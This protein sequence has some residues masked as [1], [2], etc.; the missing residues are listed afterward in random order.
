[1]VRSGKALLSALLALTIPA[2]AGAADAP[3]NDPGFERFGY[4]RAGAGGSADGGRQRCFQ[5]PGA[6]AKYRLGNECDIYGE[7]GVAGPVAGSADGP[8]FSVHARGSVQRVNTPEPVGYAVAEAWA[9]GSRVLPGLLDTAMVWAGQRFYRRED[10]PINDFFYWDATGTGGGVQDVAVGA[11]KLAY[12]FFRDIDAPESGS[13]LSGKGG[14]IVVGASLA[15]QGRPVIHR[16]DLRLYDVPVNPEGLLTIGGDIRTS[17]RHTGFMATVQHSQT[18]AL[19]GRNRLALQYGQGAAFALSRVSDLAAGPGRRTVRAVDDVT[20]QL[21]PDWSGMLAGVV[22]RR[23][24]PNADERQTWYSAGVRAIH[25]VTDHLAAAVEVG[26]DIVQPGH[27]PER[28]LTKITFAPLLTAGR[29]LSDR[30]QVRLFVTHAF[31]NRAARE[32]SPAEADLRKSGAG[33]HGTTFGLQVEL[34]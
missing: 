34:W 26:H 8:S 10:V 17:D 28:R 7:L 22:E 2:A 13:V 9:S 19:G 24:S 31:W 27:G 25:H 16:H 1:M 14:D 20:F 23:E 21:A 3:E 5:L 33:H 29:G 6:P 18:H 11:G 32:A 30:P 15:A 12:A 4:L